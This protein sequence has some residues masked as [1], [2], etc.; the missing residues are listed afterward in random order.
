M[1]WGEFIEL[2]DLKSS[3]EQTELIDSR[4]PCS[5]TRL[6]RTNALRISPGKVPDLLSRVG[7]IRVLSST[8]DPELPE[9]K[10]EGHNFQP[11]SH[12]QP[13]WCDLCGDFIW[14]L[15]KQ[16][17]RCVNCRF[18][19]HYRCRALIQ[20]DCIWERFSATDYAAVVEHTIETD[21]NVDE[22]TESGKQELTAVEV[23]HKVKEYNAQVNSNLFMNV[24]KD[25]SY[26]GFVKVQFKLARPVSVPAPKK[27]GQDVGG[28]RS[29]GVKRR[30]SF[31]LPKDASKHLHI[32]SRTTSREVIEALLKKFTVVD[33]PG[34]FALFERSERHEQVYIRKLSD[35]ERPLRLRLCAGPNE[36]VL[37]FVLKE[38]ETGEVNWHAFSMPELKNF[39]L[40][41][42]R[43]EEEHVKQIV[44][45]YTLARAKMLEA[46]S[47]STPG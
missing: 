46:L 42:Q 1:S 41:L 16:S 39:L 28:R 11:C 29:G 27:G 38:N 26:T 40:I 9:E 12:A 10:G 35:D 7:I 25:G 17:L 2:R 21:T 4:S 34:K 5:P 32:S 3:R 24:N 8:Q 36:K 47:G 14:G 22:Q 43:E 6:E 13:T 30:T 18:T 20:L 23:V 31:Y 33:N 15:Y 19:C 37:S 44:Q 45:R